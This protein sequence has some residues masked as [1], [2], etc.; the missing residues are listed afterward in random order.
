VCVR[1]LARFH[2]IRLECIKLGTIEAGIEADD[3]AQWRMSESALPPLPDGNGHAGSAAGAV[4]CIFHSPDRP[5][6]SSAGDT[7]P[8]W[9]ANR[10]LHS[11]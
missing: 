1:M 6:T 10:R 8:G 2:S 9:R 4:Y 7:L 5:S 11:R 3:R